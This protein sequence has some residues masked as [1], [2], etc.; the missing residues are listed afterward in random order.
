MKYLSDKQIETIRNGELGFASTE[1]FMSILD[2]VKN[3]N[4]TK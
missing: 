3:V 2:N 4:L 1:K